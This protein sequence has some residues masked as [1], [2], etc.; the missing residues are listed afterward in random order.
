MSKLILSGTNGYSS[1]DG[2]DASPVL[3]A[4]GGQPVSRPSDAESSNIVL[5][6]RTGPRV[7]DE[8]AKPEYIAPYFPEGA[9]IDLFGLPKEA[10]KTTFVL[11][12][13]NAL[14]HGA[15]FMGGPT[16]QTPVVYL[17]EQ[18]PGV[19]KVSA[20]KAGLYTADGLHVLHKYDLV[21]LGLGWEEVAGLTI[22]HAVA[23]GAKVVFIDTF[24]AFADM[25]DEN[26][27]PE[28]YRLFRPLSAAQEHDITVVVIRHE[29]KG[30]GSLIGG[31]RGSTGFTG[32]ADIIARL[33]RVSRAPA[34]HRLFE[35]TG[36]FDTDE[37]YVAFDGA[38]YELVDDP[39]SAKTQTLNLLRKHDEAMTVNEVYSGLQKRGYTFGDTT[40]RNALSDLVDN[41]DV[42][43][44]SLPGKGS[45]QGYRAVV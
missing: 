32:Q 37:V 43:K 16:Q 42:E 1:G 9:L 21:K 39:T 45:P 35:V 19:F 3:L 18:G 12:L 31:A 26:S 38:T 29:R 22:E 36:R 44:R 13:T 6:F 2:H 11:S 27:A 8:V 4:P 30:G 25:V 15:P 14:L 28:A 23:T 10:G 17:T 41:G 34:N 40:V 20:E 33:S 24:A 7:F 5:P